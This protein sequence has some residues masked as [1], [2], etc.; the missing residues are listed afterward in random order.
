VQLLQAGPTA[1]TTASKA[2]PQCFVLKMLLEIKDLR[3]EFG[4]VQQP[5]LF[6][7]HER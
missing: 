1:F 4:E 6:F 2:A 5:N 3:R 7:E